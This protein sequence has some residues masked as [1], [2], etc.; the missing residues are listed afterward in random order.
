MKIMNTKKWF[1]LY[2]ERH[3]YRSKVNSAKNVIGKKKQLWTELSL[4]HHADWPWRF[5]GRHIEHAF[6]A[7]QQKR[8]WSSNYLLDYNLLT[9]HCWAFQKAGDSDNDLN[10]DV[11]LQFVNNK[12]K[13]GR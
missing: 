8:S 5:L 11:K 1:F 4:D 12:K 2:I 9:E 3:F 6:N 13:V 10:I 7:F